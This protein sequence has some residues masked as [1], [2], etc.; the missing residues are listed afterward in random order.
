M[1]KENAKIGQVYYAD[2][3]NMKCFPCVVK[4]KLVEIFD[5]P[6]E[7]GFDCVVFSE[8]IDCLSFLKDLR[9]TKKD[10]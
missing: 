1:T 3:I 5:K 9:L 4:C 8:G 6:T 2:G 10:K 7:H